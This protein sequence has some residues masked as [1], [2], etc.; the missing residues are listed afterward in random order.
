MKYNQLNQI[1]IN[2]CAAIAYAF[3]KAAMNCPSCS[4]SMEKICDIIICK[5]IITLGT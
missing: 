3:I 4:N 2:N 5:R 1:N